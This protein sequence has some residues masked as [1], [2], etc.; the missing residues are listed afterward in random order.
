MIILDILALILNIYLFITINIHVSLSWNFKEPFDI[1]KDNIWKLLGYYFLFQHVEL[2][3]HDEK[4]KTYEG[5]LKAK[6][7]KSRVLK[8]RF[9]Y[10]PLSIILGLI[11]HIVHLISGWHEIW[12][13]IIMYGCLNF[14]HLNGNK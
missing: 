7:L 5:E 14:F 9:S 12:F 6:K 13:F 2:L 8:C 3:E 4:G 11:I 10:F 1:E